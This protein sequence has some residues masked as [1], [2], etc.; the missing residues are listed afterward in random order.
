MVGTFR[1]NMED[2]AAVIVTGVTVGGSS[3]GLSEDISG[4]VGR[5]YSCWCG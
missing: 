2:D 4:S 5:S 3:V 1:Q